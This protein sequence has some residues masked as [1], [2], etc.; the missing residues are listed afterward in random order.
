[1]RGRKTERIERGVTKHQEIRMRPSG[2]FYLV[3]VWGGQFK[4]QREKDPLRP[5]YTLASPTKPYVAYWDEDEDRVRVVDLEEED[6]SEFEEV[7]RAAWDEWVTK[8]IK[9]IP[10]AEASR[11]L[12]CLLTVICN[13]AAAIKGWTLLP[14]QRIL[15][16]DREAFK[17]VARL[18]EDEDES[19]VV[20]GVYHPWQ[21]LLCIS[22]LAI[23]RLFAYEKPEEVGKVI[24]VLAHEMLHGAAGTLGDIGR[25][26]SDRIHS[27]FGDLLYLSPSEIAQLRD[28]E[29]G[30][31]LMADLVR[32]TYIGERAA[33][34]SATLGS[35]L[36]LEFFSRWLGRRFEGFDLPS[37]YVDSAR[38]ILSVLAFAPDKP[39]EV[40]DTILRA[41]GDREIFFTRHLLNGLAQAYGLSDYHLRE[42]LYDK[43]VRKFL[44]ER[45]A[46]LTPA[47]A[48]DRNAHQRIWQFVEFMR[49]C[50]SLA[51]SGK[52]NEAT[53]R[54]TVDD[55]QRMRAPKPDLEDAFER[56]FESYLQRVVKRSP[57]M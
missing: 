11:R 19:G 15:C 37:S 54:E 52:L 20:L 2:E 42:M 18:S 34:G 55:V 50:G 23:K 8:P 26:D 56:L 47:G 30:K 9:P 17:R 5:I 24:E 25:A 22:P 16:L 3:T 36:I 38:A 6:A 7:W 40:A 1:M 21:D 35:R 29:E 49:R 32:L 4:P 12:G 28:S 31:E 51:K 46:Y 13:L 39:N 33:D 27:A 57:V 14:Y 44:L 53:C 48:S 41:I 10:F 45:M 43:K